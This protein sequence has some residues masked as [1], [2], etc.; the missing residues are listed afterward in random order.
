MEF[1][2]TK[3]QVSFVLSRE[4]LALILLVGQSVFLGYAFALLYTVSNTLFLTNFGSELL[5]YVFL[6]IAVVVP[7]FSFIFARLQKRLAIPG[8]ALVT[9]AF[10]AAV[11]VFAWLG[12]FL[13]Q[14]RFLSFV[15]LVCFTLGGLLCGI[16]RGAQAGHI[17]DARTLKQNYPL[18]LGGEI[19][20]VILGGVSTTLLAGNF[21]KVENILL[22][23]GGSMLMNLL[24]VALTVRN[25]RDAL[26]HS[27]VTTTRD[28]ARVSLGRLLKK[29]YIV[30]IFVYQILSAM[31]TRLV[32]YLFLNRAEAQF[33]TP[34]LL[35]RFF[36]GAMAI[37]TVLTLLFVVL[38]AGK[39]LTRFGMGFGLAGNPAGVGIAIAGAVVVGTLFGSDASA[40]FW[41]ILCAGFFDIIL[42]SGLTD[43]TVQSS[44]QPLTPKE[45][46]AVRTLVEGVGIPVA[47]GLSGA[48]LLL[49]NSI[50]GF[51]LIH[52]VYLT[53]LLTILWTV[54]SLLLYRRY[55]ES[56]KESMRRRMLD[57]SVLSLRDKSSL[58]VVERLLRSRETKEVLL[59]LELLER[60][61]HPSFISHLK[62]CLMHGDPTV[63]TASLAA[64]ERVRTAELLPDI[65]WL[66]EHET[67]PTVRA[68]AVRA[69]CSLKTD[70]TEDVLPY[71]D[72]P[73]AEVRFSALVGLFRYGGI[74]GVVA[75]VDRFK[76]M[77]NSPD[78][79]RRI[80]LAKVLGEIAD[81]S[82]YGPL[83][84][85]IQDESL[86]VRR[87]GLLSAG[88]VCHPRLWPLVVEALKSP[89]TRSAAMS[90]LMD[91][92]VA[93]LPMLREYLAGDKPYDRDTVIRLIRACSQ[94][95]NDEVIALLKDYV[96]YP[97]QDIRI[98]VLKSLALCGYRAAGQDRA[99]VEKLLL[100]CSHHAL[101]TLLAQEDLAEDEALDLLRSALA[102]EFVTARR[103]LFLLL[104]FLFDGQAIAGAERKLL[105]GI[106]AQTG[107]ALELLDVTLS[108]EFKRYIFPL[109]D[110]NTDITK[111]VESLKGFFDLDNLK[112]ENR[113]RQIIVDRETWPQSWTRACA[114][115]CAAT[116]Q[117]HD[118]SD[119]V[120]SA[121][122][123]EAH[124][125][126]ETAVWALHQLD[127]AAFERRAANLVKD[128]NPMVADLVTR[129]R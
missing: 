68:D 104:T 100:E 20:G 11:F 8:L 75:A 10:F 127:P 119:A 86:A 89:E 38:L 94:S 29:R 7:L 13:P 34:E 53:L 39:L 96:A 49:F 118:L 52:V 83:I 128:P 60:A 90:A 31:G 16:V 6:A 26:H 79:S 81:R 87:N 107:L 63:R 88:R 14:A 110:E 129:L 36:G 84:P 124:T 114:I 65:H 70:D 106:K 108:K 99:V 32:Y 47:F 33:R 72:D 91:A 112:L 116:L 126:R 66:L 76:E 40:F 1:Q 30:L 25:F 57:Q 5:P 103:S 93:I 37:V 23:A 27:Q 74:G 125:V 101:Q 82:L 85:L 35:S 4:R 71:L 45:R 55:G 24:F 18:I 58:G 64:V 28:E 115:Y 41:L 61:E 56:L 12:F 21:M 46:T 48:C 51:T 42:T 54:A 78:T 113:L 105:S 95:R 80:L 111:R 17:F 109:V 2:S 3:T 73:A 120:E 43:T 22:I 15:L 62:E 102:G 9:T 59:A 19:L 69:L 121:L 98:E 77:M 117:L 67:D 92:G 44:Y 123:D 97:D 50:E 122:S